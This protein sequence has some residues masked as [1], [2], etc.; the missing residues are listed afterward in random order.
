MYRCLDCSRFAK[1]KERKRKEEGQKEGS[2][3]SEH[4][5]TAY[6]GRRKGKKVSIVEIASMWE[7]TEY[8]CVCFVFIRQTGVNR[9]RTTFSKYA[10]RSD[11]WC[12][13]KSIPKS[14]SFG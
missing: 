11:S 14:N 12:M 10:S 7:P 6:R 13:R 2:L 5:S 3:P 4:L 8:I 9:S 1:M